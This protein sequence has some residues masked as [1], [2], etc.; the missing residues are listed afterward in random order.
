VFTA[1]V[2]GVCLVVLALLAGAL[3]R[4]RPS[5]PPGQVSR[6]GDGLKWL[7][8]GTGVSAA[9]L[10]G[11]AVYAVV[12][13]NAVA[14]PSRQPVLV[15][16]VTG[17]DWWWKADYGDFVTAN[18]I[19]IPAGQP[20]KIELESG[21][22]IHAFWVPQLA[23]KTQMIP[24]RHN[25]QWLQADRPGVYR[26]QC[27]QF[28]GLQHAHMAFEVVAQ[29]P[30]A[31]AMWRAAQVRPAQPPADMAAQAGEAVFMTH[32]AN[33]HMIRGA[34]ARGDHGPDL[35]HLQSRHLIAAGTMT[36]TPEHLKAWISNPQVFKPGVNMPATP[37]S[38]D[39]LDHLTTYLTGL[40]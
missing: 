21:D 36:N 14:F 33:C 23:G 15:I 5:A 32:C 24:G 19:H 11:M 26:G 27:T 1:I 30:K 6:E 4:K 8:I 34:D 9:V 25:S 10:V 29:S 7:F 16:K 20:V 18:E 3:V 40:K 13:L 35:T 38:H 31:F 37:L 12:A 2:C 22:V 39:D 17:Y 28:C